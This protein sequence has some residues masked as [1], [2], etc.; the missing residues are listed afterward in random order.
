MRF[1]LNKS[2]RTTTQSESFKKIDLAV[3]TEIPLGNAHPGA[4]GVERRHH[5]HEGVDLYAQ[6]GDAVFSMEAGVIVTIEPFTGPAAGFPWWLDTECVMVEGISGVLCYGELKANS[7]LRV[8][9]YIQEGTLIGALATVLM[10]DK[11]RPRNMLH[12][13]YYEKGAK[14]SCGV[15]PKD[16]PRPSGLLDPTPLL[17]ETASNFTQ[18]GCNNAYLKDEG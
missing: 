12:L 15:W 1:P 14:A 18:N 5:T 3:E 11:G 13:E 6:Q 8:G 10:S 16:T 2:W 17:L 7:N 4:F 9:Q